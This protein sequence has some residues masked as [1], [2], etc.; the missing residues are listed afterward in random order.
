MKKTI[1]SIAIATTLFAAM[2]TGCKSLAEKKESAQ[3]KVQDAKEDLRDVQKDANIEAQKIA[4]AEEWQLF[5][6]E[7]EEKISDN[8]KRIAE[9]KVKM[10]K[11][12]KVLDAQYEKR[13]DAL[14]QKNRELRTKLENYEKSQSDWETFKRE[15]NH[16]MDEIGQAFKDLTVD[17]KQ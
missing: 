1:L 8:E 10:K 7:S 17:N 3:D 13:I 9:L 12:G 14:E 4:T 16:D 11:P 15:F 5:K 2:F 6:S